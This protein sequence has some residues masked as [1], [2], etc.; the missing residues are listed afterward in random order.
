MVGSISVLQAKKLRCGEVNLLMD[1][2][3]RLHMLSP[4]NKKHSE[5]LSALQLNI[6]REKN[7]K[8]RASIIC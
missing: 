5:E 6:E 1:N 7:E 8:P 2:R 4:D 3:S